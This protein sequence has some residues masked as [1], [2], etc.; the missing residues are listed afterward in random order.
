MSDTAD[1]P[2]EREIN[3]RAE[4]LVRFEQGIRRDGRYARGAFEFIH[5]GLEFATRRKFA[6]AE[7]QGSRH[8]TGPEL[9]LALRDLALQT[10]GPLAREV[11]RSWNVHTTRD[12]GE[13]VYLMIELNLMGKRDADDITDFDD[14]YDFDAAFNNY[15]IRLGETHE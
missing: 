1:S 4:L 10:W 8:V 11:L 6:D 9:S 13:M 15:E 5:R 12:F 3:M 14:V 7:A 2:E